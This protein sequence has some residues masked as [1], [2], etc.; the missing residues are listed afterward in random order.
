VLVW[1]FSVQLEQTK[2]SIKIVCYYYFSQV[3]KAHIANSGIKIQV[4]G[5]LCNQCLSPLSEFEC[6]SGQMYSIQHYVIKFVSDLQQVSG[7]LRIFLVFYFWKMHLY[8]LN[9]QVVNTLTSFSGL[10][11]SEW[12]SIFFTDNVHIYMY[13]VYSAM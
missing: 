6:H 8:D 2:C 1:Y 11:H 10:F 12:K 9:K 13:C 3:H 4:L 7:F 5:Y